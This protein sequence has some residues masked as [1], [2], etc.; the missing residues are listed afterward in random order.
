MTNGLFNPY[1]LEEPTFILGASGIIF[2]FFLF[3][4][5]VK[6]MS[7]NK[8][9]PFFAASDLELFCLPMSHKKTPSLYG[10]MSEQLLPKR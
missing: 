3:H 1:H 9:A 10:L 7:A 5:S 4:L 2:H 6:L 8:I